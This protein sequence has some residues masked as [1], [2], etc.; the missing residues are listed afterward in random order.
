MSDLE[1]WQREFETRRVAL[2]AATQTE[3]ASQPL[4]SGPITW[5]GCVHGHNG[6]LDVAPHLDQILNLA[7][8]EKR[9]LTV[10]LEFAPGPPPRSQEGAFHALRTGDYLTHSRRR[11]E[12]AQADHD[13]FV[14]GGP[15]PKGHP[16]GPFTVAL[17]DW[18]ARA[19][20]EISIECPSDGAIE[21]AGR[22][23]VLER[24]CDAELNAGRFENYLSLQRQVFAAKTISRAERDLSVREAL[25]RLTT[26]DQSRAVALVF[27]N[28]HDGAL[29]LAGHSST[30][31]VGPAVGPSTASHLADRFLRDGSQA[32]TDEEILADV[33]QNFALSHVYARG[34]SGQQ[35]FDAV[36]RL[37]ASVVRSAGG[38]VDAMKKVC[39]ERAL[40]DFD[41]LLSEPA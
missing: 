13:A 22:V 15:P 39:R 32:V 36:S 35:A 1:T 19:K 21:A 10:L 14:R 33:I 2:S 24:L 7:H 40:P 18:L 12:A 20:P 34:M 17:L 11:R 6:F 16:P 9:S 27:G 3:L 38:A 29:I 28:S 41:R 25:K 30:K 8:A 37:T 23:Y 5:I 26:A 31:V 4:P